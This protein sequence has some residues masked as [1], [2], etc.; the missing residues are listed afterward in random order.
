MYLLSFCRN[1]LSR[2]QVRHFCIL[3]LRWHFVA[4]PDDQMP[5]KFPE[6]HLFKRF[7]KFIFKGADKSPGSITLKGWK[8]K[9]VQISNLL[10]GAVIKVALRLANRFCVKHVF[11]CKVFFKFSRVKS[12]TF[13]ARLIHKES[14]PFCRK[15]N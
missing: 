14:C 9:E 15:K 8:L 1:G 4:I 7:V 11:F 6:M 2:F 3:Q 10:T 12:K 5:K 13:W